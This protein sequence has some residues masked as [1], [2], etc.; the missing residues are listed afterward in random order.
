MPLYQR[1]WNFE[2]VVVFEP[3]EQLLPHLFLRVV[4][5]MFFQIFANLRFQFVERL[6]FAEPLGE[7]VV[8]LREFPSS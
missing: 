6:V 8:E 5:L 2:L 1:L 4:A 3:F 7:F